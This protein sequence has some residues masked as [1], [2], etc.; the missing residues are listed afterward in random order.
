M[1]RAVP[2]VDSS[3]SSAR[4]DSNTKATHDAFASAHKFSAVREEKKPSAVMTW[5]LA[6]IEH[7]LQNFH[8]DGILCWLPRNE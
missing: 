5:N 2:P 3:K 8:S 7:L 4:N 6:L 1:R